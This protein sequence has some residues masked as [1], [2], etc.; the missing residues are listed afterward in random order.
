MVG[1]LGYLLLVKYIE[2]REINSMVL[3]SIETIPIA[4]GKLMMVFA[5][6]IAVP[7]SIFPTRQVVYSSFGF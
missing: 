1:L 2:E 3:A 6:F 5:L 7:L 4:I